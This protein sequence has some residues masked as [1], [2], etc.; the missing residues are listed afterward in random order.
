[1][2]IF[3]QKPIEE[4]FAKAAENCSSKIL[5]NGVYDK[6]HFSIKGV[7]LANQINKRWNNPLSKQKFYRLSPWN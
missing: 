2:K 6:L 3:S 1:M 7:N 4:I 5:Y